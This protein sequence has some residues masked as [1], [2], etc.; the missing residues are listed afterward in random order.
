[1]LKVMDVC[2]ADFTWCK[3]CMS[4]TSHSKNGGMIPECLGWQPSGSTHLPSQDLR[5]HL[6]SQPAPQ[7][8]L[9]L[10]PR[11]AAAACLLGSEQQQRGCSPALNMLHL[12]SHPRLWEYVFGQRKQ[13]GPLYLGQ[14]LLHTANHRLICTPKQNPLV[15]MLRLEVFSKPSSLL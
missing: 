13:P 1:M 11:S 4:A 8:L 12:T 15:C 2:K 10:A 5:S 6:A 9:D 14:A 7:P 3:Y